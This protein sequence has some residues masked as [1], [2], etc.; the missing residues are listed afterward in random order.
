MNA[1]RVV[2]LVGV[3]CSLVSIA[4]QA[5]DGVT[6]RYKRAKGDRTFS[7]EKTL[8]KQTQNVM[9]MTF[10]NSVNTEAISSSTVDDID[11]K[12]NFHLSERTERIKV[13]ADL[14]LGGDRKS[15]V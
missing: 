4:A 10:D 5:D 12:G 9:G 8:T 13:K 6:L 2:M 15:V 3:V 1:R 7:I 14:G 11:D